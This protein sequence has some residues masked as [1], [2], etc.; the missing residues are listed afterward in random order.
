MPP[1]TTPITEPMRQVTLQAIRQ[2]GITKQQI[3]LATGNGKSWVT[4]FL[5]GSL[6]T[7]K[8]DT[9]FK[10]EDLLGIKYFSIERAIGARSPLANKIAGMVDSDP[11]FA[12]LASALEEALGQARGAFTP[13]FIPTQ[14]MTKIGQE[15]IKVAFANEDK[16]GKVARLVLEMLA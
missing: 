9:L 7:L 14:D 6:K 1:E 4:K 12:K 15:I 13:R 2:K 16:P 5:D 3:S 11:A 10:L 8:E